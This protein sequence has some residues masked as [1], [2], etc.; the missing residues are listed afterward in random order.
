MQLLQMNV[1]ECAV[2]DAVKLSG[3]VRLRLRAMGLH[4]DSTIRI[5]HFGWFKS[6]VQVMIDSTLIALRKEEARQIE[7]HR[8]QP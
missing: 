6:T 5:K 7:V 2:V 8:V 4:P 1:N 3:N